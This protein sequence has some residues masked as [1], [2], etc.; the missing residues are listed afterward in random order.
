VLE[1][2]RQ[3]N[4]LVLRYAPPDAGDRFGGTVTL[5]LDQEQAAALRPGQAVRVEGA[6]LDPEGGGSRPGYRVA[7]IRALARP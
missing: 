2:G 3:P 5:V 6:L 7:G 4:V 1:R